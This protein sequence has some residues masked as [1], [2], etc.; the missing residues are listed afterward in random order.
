ASI[1]ELT[2]GRLSL[3]IG[4]GA[5]TSPAVRAQF[6]LPDVSP[7]AVMRDQV[8]TVRGFFAGS[9]VDYDGKFVQFHRVSLGGSAKPVPVYLAALNPAMLRLAGEIA[10]GLT[11]NWTSA[12]HLA[13]LRQHLAEGAL[14]AGRDP[15]SVPVAQYI[16]VCVDDDEDAARRAFVGNML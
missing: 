16:R 9:K 13:W 8:T 11:P 5:Y 15:A 7:L 4:L 2:D 10:D 14:K 1:N 3:G 6:G 12:E